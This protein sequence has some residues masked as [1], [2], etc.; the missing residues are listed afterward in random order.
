MKKFS[1]S[2][3]HFILKGGILLG[4]LAMAFALTGRAAWLLPLLIGFPLAY[5][6]SLTLHEVGHAVAGLLA[7]FTIQKLAIGTGRPLWSKQIKGVWVEIGQCPLGGNTTGFATS[8]TAYRLR[9]W[10]FVSGGAAGDLTMLALLV[11]ALYGGTLDPGGFGDRLLQVALAGP[12]ANLTRSLWPRKNHGEEKC[13]F[14]SD[15]WQLI[16][17]PRMSREAIAEEL[18]TVVQHPV[19]YS[20]AEEQKHGINTA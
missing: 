11:G 7:G 13:V 9:K 18:S 4:S 20:K 6:V 1:R 5:F 16:H 2:D 17:I 3:R 15:G 19:H 10:L 14:L 12:I 8:P